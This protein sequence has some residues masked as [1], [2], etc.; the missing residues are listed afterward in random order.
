[1]SNADFHSITNSFQDVHL[2]SLASWK[3]A[4]EIS[5][6]DRVGPYLVLQEGYDPQ[7]TQSKR[8]EFVLARSGKWLSLS[9]FFRLP[10]PD[11][12][13]EFVFG[14]AAEVMQVM[15]NLPP[16]VQMFARAAEG[17]PVPNGVGEDEMA[18][19]F[20]AGAPPSDC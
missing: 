13:E 15:S 9:H 17:Q 4:H 10:I 7:D 16:K 20:K 12:R 14:S 18:A 19:A 2:V 6:R 1:M 3:K 11:R 5:P 8:D